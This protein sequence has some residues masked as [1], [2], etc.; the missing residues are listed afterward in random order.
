MASSSS[1]PLCSAKEGE[2]TSILMKDH[3]ILYDGICN[4]C[5][6]CAQFV[7]RIDKD[8]KFSLFP[9][10][11]TQGQE[12]MQSVGR[13]CE[14]LSSVVYIHVPGRRSDGTELLNRS[15]VQVYEKSD[16]AIR[17]LGELFKVPPV[18]VS[19]ICTIVPKRL[20]DCM[21]DLVARNRYSI[22]GKRTDCGCHPPGD[23]SNK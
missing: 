21:Y 10:Q 2:S 7:K 1:S 5:N 16:A 17:V 15:A 13:N 22:M 6:S 23:A 4:F 3:I 8:S 12:F 11:S 14:D 20:R 19:A 9:L 18:L